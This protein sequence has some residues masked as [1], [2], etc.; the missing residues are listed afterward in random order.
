MADLLEGLESGLRFAVSLVECIN[1]L[2]ITIEM[3]R[4]QGVNHLS[5]AL[6]SR[7]ELAIAFQPDPGRTPEDDAQRGFDHI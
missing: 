6:H 1:Q 5:P 2:V 7:R 3:H 4:P